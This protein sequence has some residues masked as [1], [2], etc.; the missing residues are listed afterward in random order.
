MKS[1]RHLFANHAS[2]GLRRWLTQATEPHILYPAFALLILGV[3]WPT[4]LYLVR[5]ERAGAEHATIVMSQELVA[6]YEAQAVRALRE[7][8]QT[9]KFVKY[10]YESTGQQGALQDLKTRSLLPPDLLFV[11]SIVDRKGDVV[12]ST[13]PPAETNVA[14]REYFKTLRQS[15]SLVISRPQQ[16]PNANGSKLQFGRRVNEAD[17]SFAGAVMI[18]VDAAYFVSG[19]ETS[20]FGEHGVLGIVGTDGV[21]RAR[22]VGE[23]VSAGEKID[24]A[25]QAPAADQEDIKAS[26]LVSAWDGVRRYTSARKLY[27]FPLTVIVGLSE[28]EQLAKSQ[29]NEQ[30]YLWWAFIG[31]ALLL[32][33]AAALGRLSWQFNAERK[34]TEHNLR[35]AAAA[36]ESQ[37]ALM[38]TDAQTVIQQVN[39]AFTEITGF[40]TDEAVGQTPSLLRSDRHDPDF[41]SAMWD[42]IQR[43]DGW[44]GEVWIR[45]KNGD[46]YPTWLTISAVKDNHGAVTNY[47][48]SH[49]DI[50]ERK[51]AEA[52]IEKLAFFDQL[53]GLPNRFLLHDRLKQVMV[54]SSRSGCYGSLLFIDLDNFKTLNDTRGHDVGDLLLQQVAQRLTQCVREGDTV[55][56]LGGDEFV[57]ILTG[58]HMDE[59]AVAT[60]VEIVAAK[61]LASINQTYLLGNVSHHCTAS[62]GATLVRNDLTTADELM[63]QADLAM[64][65]SKASG[66]NMVR[67]FDPTLEVAVK[68]RANL[69]DD[70]RRAL[71][72]QQFLLHYQ[73]LIAD[74]DRLTGAEV[75]LR[76][77]HPQRGMV[78]PT[79][80][81]S[82]AEE[83]GL[84]LPLGHWVLHTACT[85]LALWGTR[86]EMA[87]LTIAVNV[88]VHQFHQDDFADQVLA[89]LNSTGANPQRLKLELTESILLSNIDEVVKKMSALKS[90]GVGFALDDFGT[91]YSSLSYLKLLPLDQLKIDQSFVRDV[92]IDANDA[93]IVK[94][95]IALAQSLG[96]DV[97]AEGVETQAQ[98]DA[99]VSAG[100]HAYQGY[101]FSRPLQLED[102]E[103]FVLRV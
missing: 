22:R 40:T 37:E 61:I 42:F 30:T 98:R 13:R 81:I 55:A 78:L 103:K 27:E 54:A 8:D 34:R 83:T 57:V 90:R 18:S 51:K 50:T 71:K 47:I 68:A 77:Q 44:Q 25:S 69:E 16:S 63:K 46:L 64:Y 36:F 91:G 7:I 33:F 26:V 86:P 5:V 82:T 92:L 10:A 53:T 101:F 24:Y 73:P 88:S 32:L 76:W 94:T 52:E 45:R 56:R 96:L 35:I 89:M 59:G 74:E 20:K 23:V 75:M 100:C 41:Y 58:L 29:R 38:I 49:S 70:L 95:I 9:L 87:H 72:E 12:A 11:V 39:Q 85:Q 48:C 6:T 93:A 62:I 60:D 2:H 79:E 31:S 67:F 84:I 43:T 97:I 14:G 99:L 102:F 3:I 4:T 21:F 65:K 1:L 19:Y 80:F 66:R 17:G 15:G 28:D